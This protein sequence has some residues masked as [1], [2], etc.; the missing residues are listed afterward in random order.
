VA[1]A[2]CLPAEAPPAGGG[3]GWKPRKIAEQS[4]GEVGFIQV[5]E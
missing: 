1:G 4:R 3:E 2:A 5:F